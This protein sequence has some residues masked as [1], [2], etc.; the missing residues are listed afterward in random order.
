MTGHSKL[1]GPSTV[2]R[3]AVT[4]APRT[5]GAGGAPGVV[6]VPANCGPALP[7][8]SRRGRDTCSPQNTPGRNSRI[9]AYKGSGQN[10]PSGLALQRATMASSGGAEEWHVGLVERLAAEEVPPHFR[11]TSCRWRSKRPCWAQTIDDCRPW[12]A[13]DPRAYPIKQA[14]R[15]APATAAGRRPRLS[16]PRPLPLQTDRGRSSCSRWSQSSRRNA[17]CARCGTR[18]SDR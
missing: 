13:P 12:S 4:L 5:A 15:P 1:E 11:S 16:A 17:G 9:P 3:R 7:Q 2:R 8:P 6:E 14:T 18:R 10:M